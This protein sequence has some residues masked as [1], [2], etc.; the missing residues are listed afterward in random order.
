MGMDY[1]GFGLA[2]LVFW[3]VLPAMPALAGTLSVGDL[4][5]T[6]SA[7]WQRAGAE[8]E[9]DF[10]SI[11]L[12]QELAPAPAALEIYL[13]RQ[14]TRLKIEAAK[15]IEQLELGWRRRYGERV[16]LSWLEAA[17][18]RWRMCRRPSRSGDGQIFQLVTLHD[19]EAYQLLAAAP[20]DAETLPEPV[21]DLLASAAWAGPPSTGPEPARVAEALMPAAADAAAAVEPVAPLAA[22]PSAAPVPAE[23]R[24][25]RPGG[26]WQLLRSVVAV[27]G[28]KAWPAL[29]ETE[30]QALGPQGLVKGLGLT[31]QADGIEGFLEGYVWRR[32]E[33]AGEYRQPFRQHWQVLWPSLP[34]LWQGGD[35]LS[36]D[37]DFSA[38]STGGLPGG[39]MRVS[40]ELTPACAPRLDVVRWLDGLESGGPEN[41]AGLGKMACK[42]GAAS[43]G[44]TAVGVR[45][46]D[47]TA[48]TAAKVSRR[49]ALPLPVDWEQGIQTKARGEVRRLVLTVR[50][51]VSEAGNAPGDAMLRQAVAV[52]V[53]GPEV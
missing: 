35:E 29:A 14:R 52:F 10:D 50:F 39:D 19:G 17:G 41:M 4:A 30:G 1:R 27:P 44:V 33:Q 28:G 42:A 18:L 38:E 8:E 40:F 23:T 24:P 32:G 16:E 45:A 3:L 36:F 5:F 53:F 43:P 34:R 12:R 9:A 26:R 15:F 51:Q 48:G 20:A 11:I 21:L 47:F 25:E 31:A 7:A 13:P 46:A 49:V 37:L 22:E 6:A 2:W